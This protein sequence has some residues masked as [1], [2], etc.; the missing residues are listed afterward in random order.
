MPSLFTS[1]LVL[2]FAQNRTNC[3]NRDIAQMALPIIQ[4]QQ[5]TLLLCV[6]KFQI[7]MSHE[8]PVEPGLG[9]VYK[10]LD[11]KIAKVLE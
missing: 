6:L 2:R 5:N 10:R 11:V 9:D 7:A 8:S 4:N 3:A 1:S